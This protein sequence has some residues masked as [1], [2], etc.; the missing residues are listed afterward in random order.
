MCGKL[1]ILKVYL[2]KDSVVLKYQLKANLFSYKDE[3]DPPHTT[4]CNLLECRYHKKVDCRR[5]DVVNGFKKSLGIDFCSGNDKK[6]YNIMIFYDGLS[7]FRMSYIKLL[8]K[9]SHDQQIL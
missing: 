3:N 7:L 6:Y 4:I 8:L 2:Y 5:E 9:L 1:I